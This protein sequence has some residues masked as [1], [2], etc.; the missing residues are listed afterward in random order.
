MKIY[1]TLTRKKEKFKPIKS[2]HIGMYVCGPTVY[3]YIHIGNARSSVAFDTIRRYFEYKG[4]D[5]KYISNFT[6]VDDKMIN[7]ARVEHTSVPA[8]AEKYIAAFLEDTN[9]LNI[10][11]A[12]MH[13]RATHEIKEIIAFVKD[14]VDKD[15]A[16]VVDHDVY[17]RAKKFKK[18]GELSHQNIAELEEGASEHVNEKQQERKE[19]PID[20]AL[21]KGQKEPDEIAWD[22]PWGKGRPGWHIECSEMSTRYL[23]DTFDIHGGG[24]DL[25][26]PHH[27]NEIAQ[28]EPKTG[29]KFVNYWMHNGFVTVGKKETK[30]SKSLHNFVTV[31]ELLKTV[32]PQVL[33]LFMASVQ[34]RNPINYSEENL[35]QTKVIL[36]RFKTTWR[37]ASERLN[38][39]SNSQV[40]SNLQEQINETKKQFESAM[41]DD[42][43]VQNALSAIYNLLPI[44]NTNAGQDA[45]DKT[46]L[47][48]F[49]TLFD[50]WLM[51]FGVKTSRFVKH[52]DDEQ[53]ILDLIKKRDQARKNKDWIA[54]DQI[55]DQLKQMGITIE[56]TAHGTRWLRD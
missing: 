49:L 24:Q 19:D 9:A 22:S 2:G 7:E 29:K 12:T 16:Y 14:L 42:F 20:F 43:N 15:Y 32:D 26:F 55:R 34:Y 53:V 27:E 31:H 30:M 45:A 39:A 37:L 38:D 46:A 4:Y 56:D 54:S 23:G 50:K 8:L 21:W 52:S 5:V 1:N 13:P 6:D 51:V 33:R 40:D 44:I 35:A 11:P 41:D 10:E 25:I 18:Y 3:N 17:Y 48:E 36:D 28:S 47:R